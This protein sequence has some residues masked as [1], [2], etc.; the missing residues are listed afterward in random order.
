[1]LLASSMSQ[2]LKVVLKRLFPKMMKTKICL[3]LVLTPTGITHLMNGIFH[4]M[5][6]SWIHRKCQGQGTK[7]VYKETR[8]YY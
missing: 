8:D 3:H 2:L 4:Q 5:K 6:R 1:M 7:A